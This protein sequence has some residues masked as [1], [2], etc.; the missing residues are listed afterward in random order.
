MNIVAVMPYIHYIQ[1][2]PP[3]FA[4]SVMSR[5]NGDNQILIMSVPGQ[6]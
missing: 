6:R 4:H 1:G 2:V 5:V 3:G